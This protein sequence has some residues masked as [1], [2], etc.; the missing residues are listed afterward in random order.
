M[1]CETSNIICFVRL[2]TLREFMKLVYNI[3]IN[4]KIIYIY[5]NRLIIQKVFF[6][7]R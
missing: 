3:N 4:N 1:F 5:L 2:I 7:D 6:Y